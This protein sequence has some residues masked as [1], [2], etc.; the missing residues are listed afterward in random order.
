MAIQEASEMLGVSQATVRNWV[1]L[2][3]IES[4]ETNPLG[5]PF[6]EIER[7]MDE[8][9]SGNLGKLSKRANKKHSNRLSENIS[10]LSFRGTQLIANEALSIYKTS[11]KNQSEFLLCLALVSFFKYTEKECPSYVNFEKFRGLDSSIW[12][13]ILDW[14]DSLGIEGIELAS[15]LRNLDISDQTFDLLGVVYQ[16]MMHEGTKSKLGSY[17]TP[18][19]LV[20]DALSSLNEPSG[21]FLDPCCGTGQFL[22]EAVRTLGFN[23]SQVWGYDIDG[24]AVRIARF[25]LLL[26]NNFKNSELN[27]YMLDS[28]FDLA[29]G[30]IDCQTNELLESFDLIATNPPFGVISMSKRK[31]IIG[32]QIKSGEMFSLII[33]KSFRLAKPGCQL[34]FILPESFLKVSVH[35]DIRNLVLKQSAITEIVEFGKPFPGVMSNIVRVNFI[36]GQTRTSIKIKL[37]NSRDE[38]TVVQS[39]LAKGKSQIFEYASSEADDLILQKIFAR[40]HERLGSSAEWALGIVTG[41]NAELV[42]NEFVEGWRPVITG[43]EVSPF[44]T[45]N[46]AKWVKFEPSSFQQYPRNDIFSAKEK[47]FYRFISKQ[48]IFSYDDKNLI[49]LNSANVLIP[50][51]KC[52]S[53]KV[54]LCFLNSSVFQYIFL[55]KFGTFKVLKSFLCVLPFPEISAVDHETFESFANKAIDGDLQAQERLNELV[56]K[57]FELSETER[58]H[59]EREVQI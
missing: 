9:Q 58:A 19:N 55:K 16:G 52:M 40:E 56:W 47:L 53:N 57:A 11:A 10:H 2:K 29:T 24:M 39:N 30:M 46:P 5:I 51:L 54:A 43:K 31:Q 18:T 14:S 1:K 50:N 22:L 25:N 17:F 3:I 44:M 41:N 27:V 23:V 13:E 4:T 12:N 59:I 37:H 26:E 38:F 20:V 32:S 8:I 7:V 21:R 28:I 42:S 35:Q 49:S 48:L 33:E 36:K 6:S 34:S 45:Q 15:D